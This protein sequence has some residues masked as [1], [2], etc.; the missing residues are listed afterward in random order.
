M[1]VTELNYGLVIHPV[2]ES[3]AIRERNRQQFE[4]L[5]QRAKRMKE[6]QIEDNGKNGTESAETTE[7]H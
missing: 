1:K 4:A 2:E 7:I 6:Q 3:Q 5:V